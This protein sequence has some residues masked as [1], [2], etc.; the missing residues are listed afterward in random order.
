MPVGLALDGSASN[1][2]CDMLEELRVAYLLHR[3]HSSQDAPTGYDLLKMA[4]RGSAQ[5]LGRTDIGY[6]APNMAADCFLVNLEQLPLVGAQF[7]PKSMLGTVGL[8]GSVDYTIVNGV[9]VVQRGELTTLDE[10]RT[11][12]QANAV[13]RRYLDR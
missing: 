5:I 12:S 9:P 2:G 3:L 10:A 4:T 7:D 13:V 1:D 11:V 8:K 6:L